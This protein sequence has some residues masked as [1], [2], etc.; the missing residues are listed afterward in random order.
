MVE[1]MVDVL[2][3]HG[4]KTGEVLA[5]T[6][7]H[8]LGLWHS[9]VFVW[10]INPRKEILLQLRSPKMQLNPGVWDASV[11]GHIAANEDPK[12]AG[13]REV[14]EE[15]G[16]EVNESELEFIDKYLFE[17]QVNKTHKHRELLI[18]YLLRADFNTKDLKIQNEELAD[19][20]WVRANEL[21]KILNDPTRRQELSNHDDKLF[22]Y[23]INTA[24]KR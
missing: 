22:R 23:A 21:E 13:A 5:L 1:E 2:D 18:I 16:L 24:R 12:S 7:V 8:K 19:I 11:A 9:T 3:E 4:N 20:K 10:I 6:K 14:K 17:Y 15:I